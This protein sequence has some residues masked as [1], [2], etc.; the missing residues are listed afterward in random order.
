MK[1]NDRLQTRLVAKS[2]K[3]IDDLICRCYIL[4]LPL[5]ELDELEEL[6]NHQ[7]TNLVTSIGW[8][9]AVSG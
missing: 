5:H 8:R 6:P 7:T 1:S 3:N 4:Q 2:S 9:I